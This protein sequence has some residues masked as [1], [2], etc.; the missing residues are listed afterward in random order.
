MALEG[1]A[2]SAQHLDLALQKT[3]QGL[4]MDRWC[5]D[6]TFVAPYFYQFWRSNLPFHDSVF[7]W[8][9]QRLICHD[10]QVS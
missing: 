7:L 8:D 2:V 4:R 10:L 9:F 6:W 1:L 5:Q 3:R